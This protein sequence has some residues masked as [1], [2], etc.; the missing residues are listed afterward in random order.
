MKNASKLL[1][2]NED[3]LKCK[4]DSANNLAITYKSYPVKIIARCNA[5]YVIIERCI[6]QK[7]YVQ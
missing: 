7:G 1:V 4:L 6:I 3:N 5:I 2:N